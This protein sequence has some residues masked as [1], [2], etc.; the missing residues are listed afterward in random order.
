LEKP[1]SGL[2][3]SALSAPFVKMQGKG[4]IEVKGHVTLLGASLKV[5]DLPR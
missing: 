4:K 2:P 5:I 1:P 3:E